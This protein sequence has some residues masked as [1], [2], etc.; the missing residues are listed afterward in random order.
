[1]YWG[2]GRGLLAPKR[3]VTDPPKDLSERSVLILASLAGGAKHGYALI[4]DVREFAGVTL[5]PG[6]L[7]GCL[8]KL[9]ESGLIEALPAQD[10]RLPYRITVVGLELLQARL[11][12]SA[13]VAEVGLARTRKAL[14]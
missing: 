3:R 14:A 13:R 10:R 9:E 11:A 12:A 6:T 4:Q 5:G 1:M 7:Y 8:A 2:E